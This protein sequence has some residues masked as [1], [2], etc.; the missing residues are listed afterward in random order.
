MEQKNYDS[1]GRD[2]D[3]AV[4]MQQKNEQRKAL[5]AKVDDMVNRVLSDKGALTDFLT[6]QARLGKTSLANTLLVAAQKPDATYLRS[7]DDWQKHGR[8]VMKGEKGIEMLAP[9]GEYERSDGSTGMN[10]GIKRVFDVSQTTGNKEWKQY[11]P[12]MKAAIK[13]LTAKTPVPIRLD[14]SVARNIGA[15]YSEDAKAILVAK[16]IESKGLFFSV[17]RE[18]ARAE[19]C[20]N[21]FLCE[22]AAN[23][24]CIRYGIEPKPLDEIPKD[25]SDL[26]SRDKRDALSIIRDTACE[27]MERVNKNL[28]VER[29]KNEPER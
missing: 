10:F 23:I 20:D 9:T 8:S 17:A 15:L 6:V 13:A 21:T 1:Q 16:G 7:F 14:D 3:L 28:Q 19:G 29:K 12:P 4:W 22:C 11:N 25:F 24:T 18:L 27:I 26:D 5:Y 2:F